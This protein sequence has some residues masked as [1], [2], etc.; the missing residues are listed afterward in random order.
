MRVSSLVVPVRADPSADGHLSAIFRTKRTDVELVWLPFEVKAVHPSDENLTECVDLT[1]LFEMSRK[2]SF[3]VEG[4]DV[5]VWIALDD[6]P[7]YP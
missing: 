2:G 3:A 5:Q 1:S 7:L 4:G 6:Q